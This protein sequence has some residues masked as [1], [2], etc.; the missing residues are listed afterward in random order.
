MREEVGV[1][2]EGEGG[3]GRDRFVNNAQS[4]MWI[5]SGRRGQQCGIKRSTVDMKQ[6]PRTKQVQQVSDVLC[7]HFVNGH[8]EANFTESESKS[9]R[10][11]IV[12]WCFEPI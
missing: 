12:R 1:C 10:L 6:L 9:D 3:E 11:Q 4:V 8:G 7:A 5:L 2:G